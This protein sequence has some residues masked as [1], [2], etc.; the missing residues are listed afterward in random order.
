M[1]NKKTQSE[2]EVYFLGAS[3]EPKKPKHSLKWIVIAGTS[4]IVL[5]VLVW[6]LF[7]KKQQP[8][9][10]YEPETNTSVTIP[11]SE[12][13]NNNP[14]AESGYIE[15]LEETVNDVPLFVYLPHDLELSLQVGIPDKAGSSVVFVA[16]AA[17]IRADNLEIVG[18]FVLNGKQIAK[19]KAKKGFCAIVNHKITIGMEEETSLL[20]EA[21]NQ[22]GSF[23][24]QY[25]LVSK[26]VLIENNPKNKS[27]RRALAVR[28]NHVVVVE[29]RSKE[30]FHD[31]SQ[32][33]IDI[34]VSDAI[35]LVGSTTYGWYYNEQQTLVEFGVEQKSQPPNTNY[36]VWRTK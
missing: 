10:Y 29:S 8:D 2:N 19:G 1:D 32:A 13:D 30:S 6:L 20:Q 28:N 24:R 27:I 36:I 11:L 3:K 25:P 5:L 12:T 15:V 34:G 26:G 17:D 16:Q 9:Y 18:D 4:L 23:F 14:T 33:L 21:I 7:T 35:Y 22:N 31:F